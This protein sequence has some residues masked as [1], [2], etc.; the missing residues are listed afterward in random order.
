M[1]QDRI[2]WHAK[3]ICAE[4]MAHTE[5][6]IELAVLDPIVRAPALRANVTGFASSARHR[7]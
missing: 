4:E 2:L 6:L 7:F 3:I 1:L 5:V